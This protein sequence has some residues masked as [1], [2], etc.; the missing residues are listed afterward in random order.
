MFNPQKLSNKLIRERN[1]Q[2]KE[3]IT[4]FHH[5]LTLDYN[6]DNFFFYLSLRINGE[7][8]SFIDHQVLQNNIKRKF[9]LTEISFVSFIVK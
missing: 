5:Y 2:R 9:D 7:T 3:M 1:I 4:N 6:H 8:I